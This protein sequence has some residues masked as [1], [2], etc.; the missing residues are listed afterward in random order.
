MILRPYQ[1]N[2]N[3][4]K[5]LGSIFEFWTSLVGYCES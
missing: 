2:I 5:I 1:S 4:I 3:P